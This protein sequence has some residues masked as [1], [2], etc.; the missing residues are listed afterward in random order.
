MHVLIM[1]TQYQQYH[2]AGIVI[3]YVYA[4]SINCKLLSLA[5]IAAAVIAN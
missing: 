3:V 4:P 2:I 5:I 1:D